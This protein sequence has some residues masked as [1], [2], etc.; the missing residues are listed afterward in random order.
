MPIDE[1]LQFS[2]EPEF[3]AKAV[4]MSLDSTPVLN[5]DMS[6]WCDEAAWPNPKWLNSAFFLKRKSKNSQQYLLTL[7]R[8]RY[9]R[10]EGDFRTF[11][12]NYYNSPKMDFVVARRIIAMLEMSHVE[13]EAFHFLGLALNSNSLFSWIILA[14]ITAGAV[15]TTQRT[16]PQLRKAW[17][18][19]NAH[20]SGIEK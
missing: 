11:F 8:S 18:A 19:A 14:A 7:L 9:F 10:I 6:K 1:R 15:Y 16:L 4:G 2:Q 20:S 17:D 13:E 5:E 3:V 12:N